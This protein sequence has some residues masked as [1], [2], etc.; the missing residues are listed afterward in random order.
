LS[1]VCTFTRFECGFHVHSFWVWFSWGLR[2][3]TRSIQLVKKNLLDEDSD[4]EEE[5]Y[6]HKPYVERQEFNFIFSQKLHSKRVKLILFT[7]NEWNTFFLHSKR[8]KYF[9]SSLET[10]VKQ[11]V[12]C[13]ATLLWWALS[14]VWGAIRI[15]WNPVNIMI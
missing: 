11:C 1:V 10:S 6:K 14:L 4:D 3:H 2:R 13:F 15:L 9:F 12:L 8:V 5:K 7:R